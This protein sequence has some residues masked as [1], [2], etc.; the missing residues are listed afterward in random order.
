MSGTAD[1]L[2]VFE[3]PPIWRCSMPSFQ[4]CFLPMQKRPNASETFL[5]LIIR[6][7]D[8]RRAYYQAVRRFPDWCEGR[9][10]F[11]LAMVKPGLK[12]FSKN[13]QFL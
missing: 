2:V 10:L 8:I 12:G 1:G 11:D 9:G 13:S 7:K 6:N 4:R 3:G 5:R